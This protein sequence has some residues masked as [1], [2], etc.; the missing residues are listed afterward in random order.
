[1]DYVRW[2]ED[3]K[4]PNVIGLSDWLWLI[5]NGMKMERKNRA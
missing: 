2:Y 1:M 3:G 4:N 5:D